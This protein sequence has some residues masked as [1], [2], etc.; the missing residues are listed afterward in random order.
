MKNVHTACHYELTG[1]ATNLHL[2]VVMSGA[3][4]VPRDSTGPGRSTPLAGTQ[5]RSNANGVI[6]HANI[7][8][9][10]EFAAE[11]RVLA[12]RL[13]QQQFPIQVAP[14]SGQ[15]L[16]SHSPSL[17]VLGRQLKELLHDRL[18][19]AGS[20]L[21]Q[22]G[23]P[24]AWNLD[25]YGR[26]RVGRAAFG[27]DRIPDGW[28]ERCNAFDELWLPS[29]FH[30]ET[31]AASGVERSKIRVIPYALDSE[32]FS[33]HRPPLQLQSMP[34]NSFRFLAI[35]DGWLAP[36]VDTLVR[37]FIEEFSPDE[38]VALVIHCTPIRGG[39]PF[40]DV[41]A[42]LISFI[43]TNLGKKLEDVPT[44]ALLIGSLS[45]EDRASLFASSQAFV[46]PARAEATGRHC[47]EALACQLPV[48]ATNWGP[49]N[50]FL[51]EQNS[52]PV[53]TDGLVAAQPEE[54]ELFAGH[55]W[56][57][58]KLDHL[59]LQM[60]QVFQNPKESARRAA[61][62][63]RDAIDRFEWTVVLPEWIR[64]FRRLLD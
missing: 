54:N 3:T 31:F 59:R 57:E 29:E 35:A 42:E 39:D 47:L 30:R 46:Q 45:Q 20:V 10:F 36:G 32:L 23:D 61:Q 14:L 2:I 6:V 13:L 26:C 27:T 40:I 12:L 21:Y 44:I 28:A 8:G 9:E 50:D 37:A 48:I 56:A 62:G 25:F 24:V 53:T 1:L 64:N 58:S 52:F 49:L 19:L 51:T 43:E 15:Q 17:R 7:E 5:A 34:A 18:D 60:R 4:T 22:S 33:S 16:Q 11:N 55:R 38:D 41:E 63:C